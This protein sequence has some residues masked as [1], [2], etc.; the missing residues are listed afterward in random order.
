MANTVS[1]TLSSAQEAERELRNLQ[2]QASALAQR[3]DQNK[4]VKNVQTFQ[5]STRDIV[6]DNTV[7]ARAIGSLTENKSR[8]NLF[9]AL[10][11]NDK[12]DVYRFSVTKEAATRIGLLVENNEQKDSVRIQIFARGSNQII[13]D[14][15]AKDGEVRE[16]YEKLLDG[17]FK[18][19]KGDYILRIS[20]RDGVDIRAEKQISYAL[21]LSQG[22]YEKDYDTIE[23][24]ARASDN[25]FGL[26]NDVGTSN[27]TSGLAQA[28]NFLSSLP[29]IG[30]SA[31]NK[32]A[33][34]LFN[35]IF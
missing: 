13:A 6:Y 8:L 30:T 3:S 12:V 25:P 11:K 23:K 14:N 24:P 2:R 22:L 31:I 21:Q 35:S 7:N 29:K 27:L 15:G 32:L 4:N 1:S 20:R 19:E 28:A 10:S 34:A 9:S 26:S 18:L 5:K 33:G 16:N 17:S